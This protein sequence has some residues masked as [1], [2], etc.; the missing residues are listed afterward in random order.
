MAAGAKH[1]CP[2]RDL[3]GNSQAIAGLPV[4]I[5]LRHGK[6]SLPFA[7][8]IKELEPEPRAPQVHVR[9]EIVDDGVPFE[10]VVAEVACIDL[11]GRNFEVARFA[12]AH[13]K[14]ALRRR[15]GKIEAQFTEILL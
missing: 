13:F 3:F 9:A 1:P 11:A 2:S 6:E 4:K 12:G 15:L 5:I 14:A 7:I 10:A 8:R